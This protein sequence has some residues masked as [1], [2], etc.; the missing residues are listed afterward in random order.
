MYILLYTAV[1][2]WFVIRCAWVFKFSLSRACFPLIGERAHAGLLVC[3]R[4]Y[5]FIT[6]LLDAL[7]YMHI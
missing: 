3:Q 7:V 4:K 6:G 2:Q 1:G 5:S